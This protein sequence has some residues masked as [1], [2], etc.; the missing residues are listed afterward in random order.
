[1]FRYDLPDHPYD[2]TIKRACIMLDLKANFSKSFTPEGVLVNGIG[3]ERAIITIRV[4]HFSKADDYYHNELSK[5][6]ELPAT[7]TEQV[8]ILDGNGDPILDGNGDPT[9]IGDLDYIKQ[10]LNDE[11]AH[12]KTLVG[13]II[14]LRATPPEIG[15]LSL[16]DTRMQY[17]EAL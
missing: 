4:L 8:P 14:A 7:N 1:M 17:Y 5:N 11:S 13:G 9:Y 12:L 6:I 10:T 15:Q 16:I 2:A 3:T